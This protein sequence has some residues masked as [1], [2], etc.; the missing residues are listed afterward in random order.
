MQQPSLYIPHGAGPCFFMDWDPADTWHR[1]RQ[2][3]ES[4]QTLLPKRPDAVIVV[5][6]HWEASQFIVQAN[7]SPGLIFDYYGFPEETYQ[8]Q[9]SA[10]GSRELATEVSQLLKSAGLPTALDTTRGYDHGVFVPMKVAF[11]FSDIPFIQLSLHNSLDP[12]LHY[13]AGTAL[14]VL[15]EHNILLIGSGNTFHNI[16]VLLRGMKNQTG[17]VSG[18][19]FDM[20]LTETLTTQAPEERKNI[21]DPGFET[22]V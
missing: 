10:R 12:E 5:S 7:P 9:W 2:F 15:R 4:I 14:R 13:R 3:L 8:L 16:P 6:A 19:N 17:S 18:K 11:P 21:V 22:E 20:W 1:H